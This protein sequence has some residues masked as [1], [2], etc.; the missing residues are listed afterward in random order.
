MDVGWLKGEG[1]GVGG[2]QSAER[3]HQPLEMPSFFQSGQKCVLNH[4][5]SSM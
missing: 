3:W 2:V 5:V 1:C 4:Q